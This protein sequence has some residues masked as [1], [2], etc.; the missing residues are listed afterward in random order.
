MDPRARMMIGN[1]GMTEMEPLPPP[2]A[3]N[4]F[5]DEPSGYG[6]PNALIHRDPVPY[7]N[8]PA[9]YRSADHNHTLQRYGD[10]DMEYLDYMVSRLQ[11][12][13]ER[14]KFGP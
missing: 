11:K 14:E 5:I 7:G 10:M 8:R 6:D 4:P 12:A 2:D 9:G 3:R 13:A 1:V